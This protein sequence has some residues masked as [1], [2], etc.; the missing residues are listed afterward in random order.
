MESAVT[1]SAINSGIMEFESAVKGR[2]GFL[3]TD[4]GFRFAGVRDVND[5]PR[6]SYS[7]AR[8]RRSDMRIDIAWNPMARSLGVLLRM[9]AAALSRTERFVYLEPFIE[10]ATQGTIPPVVPQIYPG[11]SIKRLEQAVMMREEL[12]R[13][14]I[15]EALEGLASRL[16]EY[17]PKIRDA[18]VDTIL[19]YG[20]WYK[21]KGRQEDVVSGRES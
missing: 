12:F 13:H 8:Y 11:M 10:F 16:R 1:S 2:F 21:T 6:D 15:G 17:Y 9:D 5:D 19:Q 7:V 3:E 18:S 20:R 4:H 14:G